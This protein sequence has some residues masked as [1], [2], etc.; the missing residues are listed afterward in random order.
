MRQ[1]CNFDVAH[2]LVRAA[3]ALIPTPGF[4]HAHGCRDE[5]RHGTQS[6]CATSVTGPNA[7]ER[8]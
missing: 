3:S 5:S 2:A 1:L 6:A 8:A 7:K 4:L